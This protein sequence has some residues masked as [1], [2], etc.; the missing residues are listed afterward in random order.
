[1]TT[2]PARSLRGSVVT[3]LVAVGATGTEVLRRA[4]LIRQRYPGADLTDTSLRKHWDKADL[5]LPAG[6][7]RGAMTLADDNRAS[8]EAA[9]RMIAARDAARN[10]HYPLTADL[11]LDALEAHDG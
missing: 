3:D 6:E 8:S 9:L 7:K 2:K 11:E 5:P 4:P 1:M 10:G